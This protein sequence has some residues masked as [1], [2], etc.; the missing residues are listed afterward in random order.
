[1]NE[2][3]TL[4]NL[5]Y[6]AYDFTKQAPFKAWWTE[7]L[8]SPPNVNLRMLVPSPSGTL[9]HVKRACIQAGYFWKLSGIETNIRDPIEWGWEPLTD[10]S[11]LSH[12]QDEAVTD[13]IKPIIATC[14]CS[15]GKCSNCSCKKSSMKCLVY[16]QNDKEKCKNK[17]FLLISY[18]IFAYICI[19]SPFSVISDNSWS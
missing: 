8:I 6:E 10:S 9:E 3:D 11:F 4:C 18:W 16:S 2:F 13:N 1:M 7:H 19:V 14:S 15:K 17:W 5:I 12:W